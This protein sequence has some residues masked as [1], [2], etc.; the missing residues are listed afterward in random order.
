MI[1][2]TDDAC[3]KTFDELKFQKKSRYISYHIVN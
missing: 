2:Q 1:I 3:K